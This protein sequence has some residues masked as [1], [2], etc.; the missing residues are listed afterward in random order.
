[1]PTHPHQA[2]VTHIQKSSPASQKRCLFTRISTLQTGG[3]EI[4]QIVFPKVVIKSI[5]AINDF[6][7]CYGD[8]G[9]GLCMDV[10][11]RSSHAL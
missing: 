7:Y 8:K 4:Q 11:Q 3:S 5:D 1:M 2:G 6:E 10:L 9:A